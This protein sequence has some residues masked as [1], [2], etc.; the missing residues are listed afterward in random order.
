MKGGSVKGP[1]KD[2]DE[3]ETFI[4]N[5]SPPK[6]EPPPK[7]VKKPEKGGDPVKED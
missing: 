1:E 4:W 5:P 6:E 7:D 2:D 3:P